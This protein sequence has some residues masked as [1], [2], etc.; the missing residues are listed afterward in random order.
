MKRSIIYTLLF[1]TS[2]YSNIT[3]LLAAAQNTLRWAGDAECGAPYI[4]FV[5][6]EGNILKGF[7]KDIVD[8]LAEEMGRSIEFCPNDWDGIV[9]GLRREMYDFI[10]NGVDV[11]DWPER[12]KED[13]ALS[14]PYY[15]TELSLA[16]RT[17][18]NRI[19]KIE[20]CSY[21]TVGILKNSIQAEKLLLP[22]EGI[23]LKHYSD[24]LKAYEDLKNHRLDATLLDFPDA[25]YYAGLDPELQLIDCKTKKLEYGAILKA[26][27]Q[28]LLQEINAAIVAIQKNGKLRTILE[29]W[30]LWNNRMAEYLNDFSPSDVEP[31]SYNDFVNA[32][33]TQREKENKWDFYL[34]SLPF[35]IKAAW[36][37]I[38]LSVI[39]MFLAMILGF[40]LAAMRVY[41]I[42]PIRW[43]AISYIEIIRG[44]PLLIQLLLVFY[45]LPVL[46][47]YFPPFMES[48]FCLKPFTAGVLALAINYSASAAEN[49]RAGLFSVPKGQMEAARALGMTEVQAVTNIIFPQAFRLVIPPMTNEFIALLQDSSLVSMITITELTKA[50]QYLA[51]ANF[52]YLRTGILVAIIYLLLGLPFVRLA[53]I[54]EKKLSIEKSKYK[55]SKL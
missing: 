5:P 43:V 23:K 47:K 19:N 54:L 45:G 15:V 37:T 16:V 17:K 39:A 28:K 24:E 4:Y 22:L 35:L 3:S 21:K 40:F 18:D 30:K 42:G 10:L 34:Q 2:F 13:L 8:A 49:Y 20:D 44:T 52:D 46:A 31:T 14:I 25:F 32:I 48:L 7:E 55:K 53:K 29:R 26:N 1:F 50:Y 33:Q 6:N 9:P 11:N 27:D 36:M 12:R 41:G 38:K 51:T